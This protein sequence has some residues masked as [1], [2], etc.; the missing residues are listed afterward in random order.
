MRRFNLIDAMA[1]VAATAVGLM[2][3]RSLGLQFDWKVIFFGLPEGQSV[4]NALRSGYTGV[5][6]LTPILTLWTITLLV[7]RLRSPCP[8]ART[9]T[10]QPGF[11]CAIAVALTIAVG[12]ANLAIAT[13]ITWGHHGWSI[14]APYSGWLL[15]FAWSLPAFCGH[16]VAMAWVVQALSG[17]LCSEPSWIDRAGRAVGIIWIVVGLGTLWFGYIATLA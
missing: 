2:L 11:V 7:L 6:A 5:L 9:L 13:V 12:V 14:T 16:A 3:V 15:Q 10:R 4:F 17:N 1:L 8:A